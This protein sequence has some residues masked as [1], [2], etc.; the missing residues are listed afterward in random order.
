MRSTMFTGLIEGVGVVERL[1]TGGD[2][3][4][5]T[6]TAP[7]LKGGTA[8]GDSVCINGACLTVVNIAGD[9]VTFEVSLETL[10]ATGLGALRRGDRVNVERAL[11]LSD[12][13][14]GH[15]V[16]GHV[17]CTGKLIKRESAGTSVA[18]GIEVPEAVMPYVVEKGSVCLDGISLTVN[19]VHKTGFEVNIIPHTMGNTTLN[20][21][22]QGDTLNIET[23][24]IGKYVAKLLAPRPAEK[25][26][27]KKKEIDPEFLARYGFL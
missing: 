4:K 8:I 20:E 16:S 3:G 19:R 18:L 13:L 5:I 22:K 25:D 12:R 10:A 24:M 11:R 2:G 14:G 15:L 17:D 21:K 27:E 23:D 9:G 26:P 1:V 7:F 6:V